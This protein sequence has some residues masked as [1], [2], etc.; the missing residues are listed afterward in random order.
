MTIWRNIFGKQRP[1]YADS[2]AA[3]DLTEHLLDMDGIPLMAGGAPMPFVVADE[4]NVSLFYYLQA[5]DPDWDGTTVRVVDAASE[6]EPA[7][8]IRFNRVLWHR[9]GP[10]NEEAIGAHPL[11]RLGLYPY[12]AKEVVGSKVLSRF[13]RANRIHQHHSDSMF[14]R[15]RHFAIAFHDTVFEAISYGYSTELVGEVPILAAAAAELKKWE[16]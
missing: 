1:K 3:E 13:C 15:Y 5:F 12:T 10:P 4:H 8:V 6:G 11:S 2:N 7:A 9:L 16:S 14:E